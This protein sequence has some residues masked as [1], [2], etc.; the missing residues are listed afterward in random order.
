M[1]TTADQEMLLRGGRAG[2]LATFISL[3]MV[4]AG[5]IVSFTQYRV[6]TFLLIGLGVVMYTVGSRSQEQAAR[7]PWL[8]KQ[9]TDAL[10]EFD[11]RYHLY[12]HALP[13]E[14][15]LLTPHGVFALI[16]RGMDGKIRCFKDKWVRALTLR[17]A[18]RFFTEESLGNPTKEVQRD[19]EK[20]AEY[21]QA[22][23][24]GAQVDVQGVVVFANPA[25]QLEITSA[26][27]PVLP[28][29][30]LKSH[31]RKASGRMEMAP[32]TLRTLTDLFGERPPR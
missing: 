32:E 17:R 18:L 5:L 10:A 6:A 31:I 24:P 26:S 28:L 23:A 2:Q 7:E 15:V 11:D 12:S 19:V 30:R 25:A 13:A 14:H 4:F 22:R 20:L 3:V 29:T 8:I 1:R 9:L 16:V 21:I 27:F